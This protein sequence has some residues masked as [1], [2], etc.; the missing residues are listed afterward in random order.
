MSE[1]EKLY[2]FEQL[3]EEIATHVPD[4]PKADVAARVSRLAWAVAARVCSPLVVLKQVR[5]ALLY[6]MPLDAIERA[7]LRLPMNAP[8]ERHAGK[9]TLHAAMLKWYDDPQDLLPLAAWALGRGWD[10]AAAV[11]GVRM[12]PKCMAY[13]CVHGR[14][15]EGDGTGPD[16]DLCR[17]CGGRGYV[18]DAE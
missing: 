15:P 1:P 8:P 14:V 6:G 18:G 13:L 11:V 17:E 12:V 10:L 9:D 2:T 16:N 3:V 5:E 7:F 4:L